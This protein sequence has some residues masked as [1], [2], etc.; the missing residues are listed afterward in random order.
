MT[1][2]GSSG[3]PSPL[4][5]TEAK[6]HIQLGH[7]LKSFTVLAPP[8]QSAPP[9]KIVSP[10]SSNG[11]QSVLVAAPTSPFKKALPANVS[12]PPV[13]HKSNGININS[14]V[15]TGENKIHGSNS[16]STEELNQEMAN[17]EG[18]MKYLNAITAN[19]F[20]C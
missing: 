5:N 2:P 6:R 13:V 14:R 20:G 12:S 4:A 9:V 3:Q 18:L 17:L 19:E 8:P 15:Q 16:Y 1:A 10:S 11:R 7:P